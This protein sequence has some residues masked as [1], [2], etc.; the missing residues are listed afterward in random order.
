MAHSTG[1]SPL[2]QLAKVIL[3]EARV[4]AELALRFGQDVDDDSPRRKKQES[5]ED[6]QNKLLHIE[7]AVNTA[8]DV[9][10]KRENSPKAVGPDAVKEKGTAFSDFLSKIG[11]SVVQSQKKLDQKSIEYLSSIRDRP[12]LPPTLFRIPKIEAELKVALEE[13][14]QTGLNVILFSRQS[15]MSRLNQQSL[16]LEIAAVP[17]SPDL[18]KGIQD[19]T[20][21]VDFL[22]D[23]LERKEVFDLLIK[24]GAALEK[25]PLTRQVERMHRE[26]NR[27]RVLIWPIPTKS[28]YLLLFAGE[29]SQNDVGIWFLDKNKASLEPVVRI[30]LKEKPSE[31]QAPF[32]EFVFELGLAQQ[33]LLR[34]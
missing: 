6:I 26:E 19:H 31:N 13:K 17:P 24:L 30:D 28:C 5:L 34:G 1:N 3:D 8:M 15:E 22:F 20:P 25:L 29:F 23:H 21:R 12:Y 10:E 16:R 9:L 27:E 33:K 2:H 7:T 11:E 14:D 18:L 32:R 4:L